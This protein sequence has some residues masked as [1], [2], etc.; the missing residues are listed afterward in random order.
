MRYSGLTDIQNSELYR[1]HIDRQLELVVKLCQAQ[2]LDSLLIASGSIT[3]HF[4]DDRE[5]PFKVNPYFKQWIPLTS[6]P[7]SYLLFIPGHTPKLF[8]SKPR[9]IWLAWSG[10]ESCDWEAAATIH[11]CFDVI[12]ISH[13]REINPHLPTGKSIRG[14]FIGMKLSFYSDWDNLILNDECVLNYL[15][16]FRGYKSMYEAECL[17][18][19]NLRAVPGHHKA[20]QVFL[21][22]GSEIDIF[23]AYINAIKTAQQDDPY[24]PM[25]AL[26][27]H[28][29]ILHY[30]LKTRGLPGDGD[31]SLLIDAGC[32]FAGYASDITRTYS[33]RVCEFSELI[34]RFD[35]LQLALIA[36][37][38]LETTHSGLYE[39]SYKAI[40]KFMVDTGLANCSVDALCENDIVSYFYPH[41]L[42]H[43]LGLQVHDVGLPLRN[44]V[45]ERI[46]SER[47]YSR[48]QYCRKLESG[49]VF[50]VEPG[51]YFIDHKLEELSKSS[52]S[53]NINW[54]RINR[55][56]RFGGI[57]IEDNVYVAS[58]GIINL[59]R[60]AFAQV[61]S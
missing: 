31:H 41:G 13:R 15:R 39:Q 35:T 49:M 55:L 56:R 33:S 53:N 47:G 52:F 14:S 22:G 46:P 48:P 29:A 38:S 45:G 19:A 3:Y 25:I 1:Q 51:F 9:D 42:S 34:E 11:Q 50:T 4:M 17:Y 43:F 36:D 16:Y 32:T 10:L 18:Q 5:Y 44:E 26:D 61:D 28:A 37:I 58:Q 7:D 12:E 21:E 59:T 20:K 57:R 60:R 40:A 30:Q 6:T 54:V 23:L 2:D 24:E 27:R 8:I